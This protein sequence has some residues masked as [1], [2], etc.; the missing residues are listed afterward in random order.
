MRAPPHNQAADQA[1]ELAQLLEAEAARLATEAKARAEQQKLAAEAAV[2]EEVRRAREQAQ[3][4]AQED[5]I[6]EETSPTRVRRQEGLPRTPGRREQEDRLLWE[7]EERQRQ[8]AGM[9]SGAQALP[10]QMELDV[11]ELEALTGA[12]RQVC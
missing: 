11:A 9:L 7:T 6:L 2:H 4:Q 1:E 12:E 8:H 5:R 10:T 3:R